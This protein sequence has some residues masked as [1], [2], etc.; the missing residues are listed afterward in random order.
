[1][2]LRRRTRD[3]LARIR[4]INDKGFAG[5]LIRDDIGIIVSLAL[6]WKASTTSALHRACARRRNCSCSANER[7]THRDR[8]YMHRACRRERRAR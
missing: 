2:D 6:P 7:R 3:V 1:M 4:R 8:L 5:L